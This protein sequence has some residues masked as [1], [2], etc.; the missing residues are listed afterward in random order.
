MLRAHQLT[1]YNFTERSDLDG[2]LVEAKGNMAAQE[3]SQNAKLVDKLYSFPDI[4]RG[5]CA[6]MKN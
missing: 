6:K 5:Q 2:N 4:N 3:E 1:G